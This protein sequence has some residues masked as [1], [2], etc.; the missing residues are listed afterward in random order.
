MSKFQNDSG[1]QAF[2]I[3]QVAFIV[4]PI[5]AGLDK[6][7]NIL[8]NW[9][10][11]LAPQASRILNGHDQEFM[12]VAGVV[13][14]VAGIGVFFKPKWFGY[15]I[16]LW[17]LAIVINLLLTKVYFDIALRDI[18]LMLGAFALGKL[19]EKYQP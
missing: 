18:G 3:L 13:E 6:F 14:I 12:M 2:R 10:I 19:A 16:S 15:I 8:V 5:L 7:F 11:Y 4:A 1:Y 9:S 17:L